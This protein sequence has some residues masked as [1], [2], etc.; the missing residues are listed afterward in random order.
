MISTQYKKM[1]QAKSVIRELS[2]YAVKRGEEIGYENVFDYSLGNPSV[3][4]PHEFAEVLTALLQNSNSTELHGY[5]PTLGILPVRKTIAD[6]LNRRFGMHYTE[7]HIF[8]ASG[9]AGAIAHAV[10]AVVSQGE[11]VLTFA[12]FFPE[13][14]PYVNL[15]GAVLQVVPA[16]TADFQIDFEAF[17]SMIT[18]TTA[19]VLINT[20]NNP[21]GVIYETATIQHLAEILTEKSEQFGHDIYLISDEPYREIVFEGMESP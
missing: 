13:Y 8:M 11:E 19:A 20:P 10:R 17:A 3:P 7:A 1:M 6:S 15:T 18:K 12:P 2:A 9:A 16:K 21:S 4:V 5:S 14:T